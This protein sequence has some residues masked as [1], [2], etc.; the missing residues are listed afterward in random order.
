VYKV[1]RK[2]LNPLVALLKGAGQRIG[3]RLRLRFRDSG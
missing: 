2:V 3:R 1:G